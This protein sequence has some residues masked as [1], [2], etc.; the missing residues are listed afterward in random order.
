V[1]YIKYTPLLTDDEL[2]NQDHT[3]CQNRTIST[4][5]YVIVSQSVS[6]VTSQS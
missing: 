5:R 3:V 1:G 2:L 6:D 4:R